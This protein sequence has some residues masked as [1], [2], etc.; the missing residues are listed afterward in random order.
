MSVGMWVRARQVQHDE[1]GAVLPIVVICL[2]LVLGMSALAIDMGNLWAQRR[3]MVDA[4]DAAALAAAHFMSQQD[5]SACTNSNTLATAQTTAQSLL[6]QNQPAAFLDSSSGFQVWCSGAPYRGQVTVTAYNPTSLMF[7]PAIGIKRTQ[8]VRSISVAQWGPL[9]QATGVRPIAICDQSA[10]YQDWLRFG[11]AGSGTTPTVDPNSGA[12]TLPPGPGA[13]TYGQYAYSQSQSSPTNT[14]EYPPTGTYVAG[15]GGDVVQR[16]NFT[17]GPQDGTCGGAPGNWGFLQLPGSGNGASDLS[18]ALLQGGPDPVS[19]TSQLILTKTGA[20]HSTQA[21]LA[22]ISCGPPANT[23]LPAQLPEQNCPFR[24][25]IVVFDNVSGNGNNATFHEVNQLCV[26][27][28]GFSPIVGNS[29]PYL[30]FEFLYGNV[31]DLGGTIGS[32]GGGLQGVSLCGGDLAGT[33]TRNS[34]DVS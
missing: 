19:T 28:R 34:C 8:N 17:Q 13:Q 25:P 16:I 26:V 30:D 5:A 29:S 33:P 27:L 21:A 20:D 12:I 22:T 15:S 23:S 6:T 24:F 31:C 2:I 4:T 7:A 32:S 9:A 3:S 14:T 10:V 11:A 1:R 18:Q